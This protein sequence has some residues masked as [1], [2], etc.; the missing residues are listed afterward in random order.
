M[1]Y[2]SRGSHCLEY[3]YKKEAKRENEKSNVTSIQALCAG[4]VDGVVEG[5]ALMS[6]A[7][8]LQSAA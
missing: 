6:G 1:C 4:G 5:L 2:L 7:F 3:V 8:P